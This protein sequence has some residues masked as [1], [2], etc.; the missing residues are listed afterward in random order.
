[1]KSVQDVIAYARK[2]PG[3]LNFSSAGIGTPPHLIGEMFKQRLGLDIV[4]VPT[5]AAVPRSRR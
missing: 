1:M 3:K 5:R 4:H 2:N